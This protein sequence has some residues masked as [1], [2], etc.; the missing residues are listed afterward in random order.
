VSAPAGKA[1]I[2]VDD[3]RSY[4]DL[5]SELLTDC[6]G[7]PVHVF[8]RP[9]EAL[10]ALPAL[11]VGVVI[12]DYHMPEMTGLQFIRQASGLLPGVPF[13]I[14]TGH[15]L[16]LSDERCSELS[17]LKE[18]LHK[19]LDWRKLGALVARHWPDPATRPQPAGQLSV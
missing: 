15:P 18:V 12:T 6:L 7:R 11:D 4:G 17:A 10:A 13:I 3:E 16:R 19:P 9:Q 5:L 14:I 1:I 8:S 2:V